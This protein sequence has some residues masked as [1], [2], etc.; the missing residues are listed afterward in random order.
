MTNLHAR[1]ALRFTD[2]LKKRLGEDLHSV[3]LYGSVA[4]GESRSDSDI[5]LLV[6]TS[7]YAGSL[8]DK[9][10]Y[11]IDFAGQFT[12]F[13]T[14]IELSPKQ[15]E[16]CLSIGDPFLE[17]VLDEGKLLHDDGTFKNFHDRIITSRA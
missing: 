16:D 8:I 17:R 5:D 10:A 14:P 3:V 2:E 12:T 11:E 9:I 4:R 15:I 1:T 7:K 13:L 6:V